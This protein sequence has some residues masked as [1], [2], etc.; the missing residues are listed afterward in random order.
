MNGRLSVNPREWGDPVR[1]YRGA[2]LTAYSRLHDESH[3]LYAVHDTEPFVWLLHV[4]P[5]LNH[6]LV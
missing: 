5:V 2:R 3:V 1:Y 4:R 6:P